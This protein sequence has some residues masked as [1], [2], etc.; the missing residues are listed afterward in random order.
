MVLPGVVLI[1]RVGSLCLLTPVK[2]FKRKGVINQN[3]WP[4]ARLQWTEDDRQRGGFHSIIV[5]YFRDLHFFFIGFIT[6][7]LWAISR[8]PNCTCEQSFWVS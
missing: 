3:E 8:H 1:Q 6:R 5:E 4:G 2:N 7:G